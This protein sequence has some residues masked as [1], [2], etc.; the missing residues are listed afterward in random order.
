MQPDLSGWD[1]SN[2]T[3]RQ[4]YLPET[5]LHLVN[6][7]GANLANSVFAEVLGSGLSIA[8]SPDG[9]LLAMGDTNGEIHLW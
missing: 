4:A 9:K 8:F 7:A 5:N 1:F 2:L 6:F 3:V